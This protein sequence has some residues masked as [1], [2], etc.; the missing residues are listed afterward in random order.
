MKPGMA[1][2]PCRSITWV[3]GPIIGL[4]S[5]AVPSAWIRSLLIAIAS[6]SG[7]AIVHGDDAAVGEDEIGGRRLRG[8]AALRA[9]LD[10]KTGDNNGNVPR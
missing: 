7:L 4:I 5:A 8:P 1:S 2:C 6:A 9:R 3:L 10:G